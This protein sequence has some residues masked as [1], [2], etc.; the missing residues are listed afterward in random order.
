MIITRD[1]TWA[2]IQEYIEKSMKK[3]V[4]C[5]DKIHMA[6]FDE[7]WIYWSLENETGANQGLFVNYQAKFDVLAYYAGTHP[8]TKILTTLN[9]EDIAE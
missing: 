7:A 5:G 9:G 6:P 3:K 8:R 4:K 1:T 2:Q